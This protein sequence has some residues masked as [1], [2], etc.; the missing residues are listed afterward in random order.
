MLIFIP[1]M[2]KNIRLLLSIAVSALMAPA[3]TAQQVQ[4][5]DT[6]KTAILDPIADLQPTF[7]GGEKALYD[8]MAKN[9]VYPAEALQQKTEGLVVLSFLIEPDGALSGITIIRDIG[10]GCGAA[11]VEMVK[12]MPKWVQPEGG[13]KT[14]VKYV[15]PVKFRL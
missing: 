7:P 4:N 2:K 5:P 14:R 15:L 12:K 6:S 1:E 11:A 9:L 8:F 3:L 10:Y 13:R